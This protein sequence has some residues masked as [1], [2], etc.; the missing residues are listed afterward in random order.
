MISLFSVVL[1]VGFIS[2]L[3]KTLGYEIPSNI[4][5]FYFNGFQTNAS[6]DSFFVSI[7]DLSQSVSH[8]ELSPSLQYS[9]FTTL[10]NNIFAN[11]TYVFSLYHNAQAPDEEPISRLTVDIATLVKDTPCATARDRNVS[12]AISLAVIG[13][14]SS[15]KTSLTSRP[16]Y[17]NAQLVL[18]NPCPLVEIQLP[19][20]TD[21][22]FEAE[23]AVS[24]HH[25]F[26]TIGN[27]ASNTFFLNL[28]YV[29]STLIMAADFA[30]EYGADCTFID[31]SAIMGPYTTTLFYPG[32]DATGCM[33]PIFTATRNSSDPCFSL[34]GSLADN[35]EN[36]I[37]MRISNVSFY[38]FV[39]NVHDNG[40]AYLRPVA[41]VPSPG[42]LTISEEV[43]YVVYLGDNVPYENDYNISQA[44]FVRSLTEDYTCVPFSTDAPTLYPTMTPTYV[45]TYS[46]TQASNTD[47]N[48]SGKKDALSGGAIA[49]IVI[50]A[51]AGVGLLVLACTMSLSSKLVPERT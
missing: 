6:S 33:G 35:S 49:G 14:A 15:Y 44:M 2:H 4:A 5:L 39:N 40:T 32:D 27:Y 23:P 10:T 9:N 45:P 18:F 16:S 3:Q 22:L 29:E 42:F 19:A 20:T 11:S 26:R 31:N 8:Q 30:L 28:V 41:S 46:P 25:E 43:A 21:D 7:S 37:A 17:E 13:S 34:F 36:F 24:A 1:V 51:L 38:S 48:G 50:G 12:A 47:N